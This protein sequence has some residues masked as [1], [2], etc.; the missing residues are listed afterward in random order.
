VTQ[1][2]L[3][4]HGQSTW[5]AEGRWQGRAD[6]PLSLLGEQQARQAARQI[7]AVDGL[8]ASPLARAWR[9]AEIIGEELGVGPVEIED[10]LVERAVGE[11]TGLTFPEIELRWPG[12]LE[13]RAWPEGFEDDEELVARSMRAIRSLGSRFP[14]GTVVAVTHGGVLHALER[15]IGEPMGRFSNL[16]G[17]WLTLDGQRI[18]LGGRVVLTEQPTGGARTIL[19]PVTE[20]L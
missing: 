8:A 15:A 19:Q 6:P 1:I 10:D 13:R 2:L 5:N 20:Q 14:A 3:L 9:S 11:W 16:T 7:G 18:E 17:R 12:A 4:R